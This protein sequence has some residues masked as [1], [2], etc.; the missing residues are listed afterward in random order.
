MVSAGASGAVT[1]R[2]D[3]VLSVSTATCG[4]ARY[5]HWFY[6]QYG[7]GY[8]Y[9]M[10]HTRRVDNVKYAY[11]IGNNG[12]AINCIVGRMRYDAGHCGVA[13]YLIRYGV[14]NFI[15]YVDFVFGV[16]P[17]VCRIWSGLSRAVYS[18]TNHQTATPY[19]SLRISGHRSK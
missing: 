10:V 18:G 6:I 14:G 19:C 8:R 5:H 17:V 2:N 1:L 15:K 12:H 4:R 9:V 11:A 13:G 7:G 3:I 16:S